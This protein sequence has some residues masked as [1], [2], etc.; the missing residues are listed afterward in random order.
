[1]NSNGGTASTDSMDSLSMLEICFAIGFLFIALA[2][3]ALD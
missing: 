1:V 3:K 2:N